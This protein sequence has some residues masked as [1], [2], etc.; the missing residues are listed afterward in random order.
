MNDLEYETYTGAT[1]TEKPLVIQ[2][3]PDS[4]TVKISKNS[5]P[6]VF[7]HIQY[8]LLCAIKKLEILY[9]GDYFSNCP[10]IFGLLFVPLGIVTTIG[11]ALVCSFVILFFA[12]MGGDI[13]DV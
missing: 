12:I 9:K 2:T 5:R 4:A 7:G 1:K 10:T 6:P 11:G 13:Q 3:S 8:G